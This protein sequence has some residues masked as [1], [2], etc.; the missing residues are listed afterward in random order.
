MRKTTSLLLTLFLTQPTFAEITDADIQETKAKA[1]AAV[2]ATLQTGS[3]FLHFVG[4]RLPSP[5]NMLSAVNNYVKSIEPRDY[6]EMVTKGVFSYSAGYMVGTITQLSTD[7]LIAPTTSGEGVMFLGEDSNI[8]TETIQVECPEEE[9]ETNVSTTPSRPSK[10]KVC[11]EVVT[12]NPWRFS[13]NVEREKL[14]LKLNNAITHKV[15]VSYADPLF[16]HNLIYGTP[17]MITGVMDLNSTVKPGFTCLDTRGVSK[18]LDGPDHGETK[19]FG[20][21]VKLAY[22]G[23]LIDTWELLIQENQ[24]GGDFHRV[25]IHDDKMVNCVFEAMSSGLPVEMVYEKLL[26]QP[27]FRGETTNI[28]KSVVVQEPNAAYKELK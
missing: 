25:T 8:R 4:E 24:Y 2:N 11:T 14:N 13:F 10:K 23:E 7:G 16:Q 28:V 3:D 19:M 6:T 20:I 15:M 22:Q 27:S 21:I 5:K 26:Y 1:S 9:T 12:I 17:F 18:V